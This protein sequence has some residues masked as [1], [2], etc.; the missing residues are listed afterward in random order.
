MKAIHANPENLRKILATGN[1]RYIIPEFQRPYAWGE[2]EC[3]QLWQDLYNFYKEREPHSQYFLGSIVQYEEENDGQMAWMVVDGQQRLTTLMLLIQAVYT[4]S[5]MGRLLRLLYQEDDKDGN[6]GNPDRQKCILS[7]W[8]YQNADDAHFRSVLGGTREYPKSRQ[9]KNYDNFLKALKNA[10]H[11]QDEEDFYKH[12]GKML[13]DRL[14]LLPIEC[15]SFDDAL[16]L[17][18]TINNRGMQLDDSDIFKSK[19]YKAAEAENNA[20]SFIR[21]W[22]KLVPEEWEPVLIKT[23]K[24]KQPDH[25]TLFR[26]YSYI[27]RA[28]NENKGQ[29]MALREFFT[30]KEPNYLKDWQRTMTE[31]QKIADAFSYL[32]S[33]DIP[34][35]AFNWMLALRHYT[36]DYPRY[37]LLAYLFPRINKEQDGRYLIDDEQELED[38]LAAIAKYAYALSL[39]GEAGNAIKAVVFQAL[40]DAVKKD[41]GQK[42]IEYLEEQCI[43]FFNKKKQTDWTTEEMREVLVYPRQNIRRGLLYMLSAQDPKQQDY[44]KKDLQIEHILPHSSYNDYDEWTEGDWEDYKEY[45]G[46]I[47]LLEKKLNISASNTYFHKKQ[48]EYAGSCVAY[49]QELT[50]YSRWSDKELQRRHKQIMRDFA[51][52][53]PL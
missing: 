22:K 10:F 48:E 50:K 46:N 19:L 3:E 24:N 20:K 53:F 27:I 47:V 32:E 14:V 30:S 7:S 52:L 18:E 34:P 8:V 28:R 21:Q 1:A 6:D 4:Q 13:M 51:R 38:V 15:S 12:F 37:L 39:F 45:W 25:M 43:K 16:K 26:Y 49:A 33:N 9:Q 17:F 40:I 44:L 11:E 42:C 5:K 23:R 36:N 35:R 31:L 29:E 2:D 41:E